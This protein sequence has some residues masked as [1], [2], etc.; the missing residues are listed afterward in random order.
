[1]ERQEEE[2]KKQDEPNHGAEAAANQV[3]AEDVPVPNNGRMESCE[4]GES[5]QEEIEDESNEEGGAKPS[6][7]GCKHYLRAC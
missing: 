6:D 3:V 1:M 2:E 5:E 4:G 7:L